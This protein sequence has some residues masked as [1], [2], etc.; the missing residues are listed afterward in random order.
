M[1]KHYCKPMIVIEE[2]ILLSMLATSNAN[3]EYI[4]I[5]PDSGTPAANGRRDTW[6]DLWSAK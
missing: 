1:K 4:P 6:G 2:L 5:T 3:E